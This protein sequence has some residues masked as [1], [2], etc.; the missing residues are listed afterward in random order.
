MCSRRSEPTQRA[1]DVELARDS[2]AGCNRL[3]FDNL[4]CRPAD[5]AE[6]ALASEGETYGEKSREEESKGEGQSKSPRP[7]RG[8]LLH[9]PDRPG[10]AD[11]GSGARSR[12]EADP[13]TTSS[14]A[15]AAAS[16]TATPA[17][18]RFITVIEGLSPRARNDLVQVIEEAGNV[19][20]TRFNIFKGGP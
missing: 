8:G 5:F 12:H 14:G 2:R 20:A 7:V 18:R 10:R 9:D 3:G 6:C 1:L 17:T 15:A 4:P 16:S 13:W 19:T 11:R